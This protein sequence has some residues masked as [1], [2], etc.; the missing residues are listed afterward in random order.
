[1]PTR[2]QRRPG[3]VPGDLAGYRVVGPHRRDH[4]RADLQHRVEGHHGILEHHGDL[5]APHP[6]HRLAPQARD[7]HSVEQHRAAG[8]LA[9]RL[10]EAEDGIARDALAGSG[11]ADEA[12]DASA[13]DREGDAVDGLHD[14][15]LR[16]ELRAQ[17]PDARE[18]PRSSAAPRIEDCAHLVAHQVDGHD[19]EHECD[20]GIDGDPV[21][22]REQELEAVGD[23]RSERRLRQGQAEP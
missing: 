8:D 1:M 5:R 14:A 7:V 13:P 4:L 21:A 16:T 17:V 15:R 9:R 10:D 12:E 6:A 19:G 3:A 22:P 18:R 11:F 2:G 23:E 20:A